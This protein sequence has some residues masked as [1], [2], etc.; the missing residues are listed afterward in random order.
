MSSSL[1]AGL[2]RNF[3]VDPIIQE[4]AA[5]WNAFLIRRPLHGTQ[6][7]VNKKT[8][9]MC[10]AG[11]IWMAICLYQFMLLAWKLCL[12]SCEEHPIWRRFNFFI[13][14]EIWRLF[15]I[16]VLPQYADFQLS[17][18]HLRTSTVVQRTWNFAV[19]NKLLC[20]LP[21]N[22]VQAKK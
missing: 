1:F 19:P 7:F 20:F 18:P 17:T 4:K 2:C 13:W 6:V 12:C 14:F 22:F 16:A 5:T 8:S 21:L 11:D 3:Q 9:N 10:F 15:T